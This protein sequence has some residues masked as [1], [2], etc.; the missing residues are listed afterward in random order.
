MEVSKQTFEA[1]VDVLYDVLGFAESKLEEY[2]ASMKDTNIISI[3][4]EEMFVNVASYA[5]TDGK[6]TADIS[7]WFDEGMFYIRLEDSGFE[8]N[9]LAKIDPDIHAQAEDRGIGGLGIY[10]V[11]KSMDNCTYE[12][13]DDKNIFTMGKK[14][15]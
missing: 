1:S 15:K 9:P 3:A 4:L 5:Y 6:G 7:I 8:F 13:K 12:R 10:M 14:I 11:K 2:G